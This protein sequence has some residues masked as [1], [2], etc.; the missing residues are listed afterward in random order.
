MTNREMAGLVLPDGYDVAAPFWPAV[1]ATAV[2]IG[3]DVEASSSLSGAAAMSSSL[4]GFLPSF[5][6][7]DS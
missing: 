2:R 6:C 5:E 7:V 1:A 4:V 3:L